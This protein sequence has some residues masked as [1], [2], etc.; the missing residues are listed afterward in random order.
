MAALARSSAD[1]VARAICRA[2]ATGTLLCAY[3]YLRL[4]CD[5]Y[6]V[7]PFLVLVLP[8]ICYGRLALLGPAEGPLQ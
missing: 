1:G 4:P 3:I 7:R 6:P 2:V 5:A 8:L